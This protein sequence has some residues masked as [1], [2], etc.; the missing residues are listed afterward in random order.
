MLDFETIKE[1]FK[2]AIDDSDDMSDVFEKWLQYIYEQG[3]KDAE[4]DIKL[5]AHKENV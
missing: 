3:K 5:K 2:K 4:S 1:L